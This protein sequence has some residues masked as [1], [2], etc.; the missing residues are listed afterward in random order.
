MYYGTAVCDFSADDNYMRCKPAEI[1]ADD[2]FPNDE[3]LLSATAQ[4]HYRKDVGD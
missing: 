3:R 2:L 1:A 4:H